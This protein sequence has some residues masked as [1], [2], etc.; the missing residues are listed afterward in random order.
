MY[1]IGSFFYSVERALELGEIRDYDEGLF[2]FAKAGISGIQDYTA[3]ADKL[4]ERGL[5][6]QNVLDIFWNNAIGVIDKC[7]M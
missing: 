3:I 7:C 1:K 2:R 6:Q 5:T 4:L